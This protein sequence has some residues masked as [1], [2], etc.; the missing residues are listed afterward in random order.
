MGA[1]GNLPR[2]RHLQLSP[3]AW[4]ALPSG[5]LVP[6]QALASIEGQQ[7]LRERWPGAVV[8][9]VEEDGASWLVVTWQP[10]S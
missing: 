1:M 4:F 10:S 8:R 3:A 7:L 6:V 5:G 9:C 2:L